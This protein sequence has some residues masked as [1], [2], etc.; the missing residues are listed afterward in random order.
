[1][2]SIDRGSTVES[3]GPVMKH[4]YELSNINARSIE[5]HLRSDINPY[6]NNLQ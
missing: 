6:E 5:Q 4:K 3:V 2:A 1:M